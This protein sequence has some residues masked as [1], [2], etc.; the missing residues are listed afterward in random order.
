VNYRLA[1]IFDQE[2]AANEA[3][4]SYWAALAL[5]P[6][7]QTIYCKIY[8]LL[9]PMGRTSEAADV[10]H[11]AAQLTNASPE[12]PLR[13]GGVLDDQGEIEQAAAAYQ[14]AIDL[15]HD[16]FGDT[17][18]NIAL[19][20]QDQG[21]REEARKEFDLA[22]DAYRR[23]SDRYPA[24]P[25]HPCDQGQALL[26]QGRF[27]EA[28]QS[29]QRGDKLAAEQKK[30]EQSCQWLKLAQLL[31]NLDAELPAALQGKA[32]PADIA[33]ALAEVA[34][35]PHRRLYAASARLYARAF[36]DN[37]RLMENTIVVVHSRVYTAAYT[38]ACAAALAAAGQGDDA[39]GLSPQERDRLRKQAVTWLRH[40]L[41]A[42]AD[43]VDGRI[44]GA[45]AAGF[46]GSSLGPE[47]LLAASALVPGRAVDSTELAAT[48]RTLNV[49]Q[50][51]ADLAG[52]RDDA[53]LAGLPQADQEA[54]RKL[55]ADVNALLERTAP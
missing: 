36:A 2:K 1:L 39:G 27:A 8:W 47:S 50:V 38:A 18:W 43:R 34:Q 40:M 33:A 42:W 17:H 16:D 7:N 20:R 15:T 32:E 13:L 22:A 49:W 28:I 5:R 21:R 46:L 29:L 10:A 3:L 14:K 4:A 53:A 48:H 26:R 6:Q 11:K 55:W 23:T 12:D 19:L 54:C 52:L 24:N 25:S 30:D 41:D 51:N 44:L 31:A 45:S 9:Q 37:P 35:M